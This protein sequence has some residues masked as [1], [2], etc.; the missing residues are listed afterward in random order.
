MSQAFLDRSR[1][2]DSNS[3]N[4]KPSQQKVDFE[5]QMKW[6]DSIINAD[7][8]V[9][10]AR[11]NRFAAQL[12][13]RDEEEEKE[14][15]AMP[16]E[17]FR[18]K[19]EDEKER[20]AKGGEGNPGTKTNMP[21]DVQNK[22]ENSFGEDFSDVN[23]HKD[24]EQAPGLGALAYTQGN[25]IHFAP[26]QYEPGSQKGQELLGHEL[27]HVVQQRE[28]RVKPDGQQNKADANVN[29]DEGLEKEA[30][31][32]GE[33][34]AQGKK[35]DVKGERIIAQD[36]SPVESTSNTTTNQAEVESN[37]EDQII[38]R[39]YTLNGEE[40]E[41][42][43]SRN[44]MVIRN[45]ILNRHNWNGII[46]IMKYVADNSTNFNY[47][48][49]SDLSGT[50]DDNEE[51]I[52]V[53]GVLAIVEQQVHNNINGE[54]ITNDNYA[55]LME[56]VDGLPG[57]LFADIMDE[58]S[59]T[60]IR[61]EGDNN[62][63]IDSEGNDIEIPDFSSADEETLYD[64]LEDLT[65]ARN[66]LWSGNENIVNL[67][68]LRRALETSEEHDHKVQ[69]NDTLAASW[70]SNDEEGNEIKHCKTYVA[71]TEPGNRDEDRMITPQT[72]T[73]LLGLHQS[74]QPA[75]RTKN[76][77]I[78]GSDEDN[79]VY[80]FDNV[81]W[82]AGINLHPG[83]MDNY[84]GQM[85]VVPDDLNNFPGAY[86]AESDNDFNDNVKLIEVFHILSKYGKDNKDENKNITSA[87][88]YLKEENEA[89]NDV[90]EAQRS[91][92]EE[93]A[94]N[95]FK[96]VEELLEEDV[97]TSEYKDYI[98]N[99]VAFNYEDEQEDLD[100]D[101]EMASRHVT[102]TELDDGSMEISEDDG[103]VGPSSK[104]CQVIYGGREFYDFWWNTANKAEE[105]G[106]R[107]WY[108]T[109]I[110]ITQPYNEIIT[111]KGELQ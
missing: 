13:A 108:Y 62:N 102:T 23:I 49:P 57:S 22:M 28:G 54:D 71:T 94:I 37:D 99:T 87:Y 19:P 24:S 18:L 31:E 74:R 51:I 89:V 76:F 109:L 17:E 95:D 14:K 81:T 55:S 7:D 66:G 82:Q 65:K 53:D 47:T 85:E 52:P 58:D 91:D 20:Q 92:N 32:L 25:D 42:T 97:F 101:N 5:A 105:S 38:V 77:A 69:W 16:D 80:D 96:R 110:D 48:V 45:W 40:K 64:F 98:K 9:E 111:E 36:S 34:A 88:N 83:G 60:S 86:G 93:Q 106:Q 30:D 44:I 50:T 107:R 103:A 2:N 12:F 43:I 3:N 84:R 39:F 35:A 100:R 72:M 68:G 21:D 6:L 11:N 15:Q 46:N 78:R 63:M 27:S 26:G 4:N 61:D 41:Q 73:V 8:S 104:G 79:N 29:T 10:E 75:G 33:Q 1:Q 59:L 67:T 70:I 56:G 90:E